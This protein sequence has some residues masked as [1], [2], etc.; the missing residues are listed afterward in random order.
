MSISLNDI[1]IKA[2]VMLAPMSGISDWP[3]REIVRK[4]GAGLVFSEMIASQAVLQDI[5]ASKRIGAD[6]TQEYPIAVQI[7]GCEPE[8]IAQ[9]ARIH[10]DR[11]AS[12]IDINFGCPVKKIVKKYAGSALMR[13]EKL[14]ASIMEETVKAVDVPVTV[15]MRL[16]WDHENLN[17]PTLA[18]IAQDVGVQMVTVH[19]RTRQ[20]M[21]NGQADWRAVHAVKEAM[22]IPLIV[23]GDIETLEDV[24]SALEQSGAQGVMI[25]RGCC[26]RP[27]FLKEVAAH[28]EGR[29]LPRR[30]SQDQILSIILEHYDLI[31]SYYG[32]QKGVPLARKHLGWY[33]QGMS[34]AAH[35]REEINKCKDASHVKDMVCEFFAQISSKHAA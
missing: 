28:L 5:K 21:Y 3:F 27:W 4:Y 6:Y 20:Q 17:A 34:G 7:A 15:K 9:A 19:G 13:D 31:L 29:D 14:A 23:N 30:P 10:A 22:T 32:L 16:G 11:G 33:A 8:V 25:G 1:Q 2:P 18:K 35:F 12:I 24:D 26:G